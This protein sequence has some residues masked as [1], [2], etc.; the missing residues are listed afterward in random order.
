MDYSKLSKKQL[1]E[2]I[3]KQNNS[4]FPAKEKVLSSSVSNVVQ[5]KPHL[6]NEQKI[7]QNLRKLVSQLRAENKELSQEKENL[8][9]EA[10]KLKI[11]VNNI[12]VVGK[13]ILIELKEVSKAAYETLTKRYDFKSIENLSNVKELEKLILQL[14]VD[15]WNAY[16]DILKYKNY[17]LN[18]SSEKSNA[19]AKDLSQ[20]PNED[21]SKSL[22][23]QNKE[24]INNEID[25]EIEVEVDPFNVDDI[26]DQTQKELE[27]ENLDSI[28]KTG[29]QKYSTTEANYLPEFENLS[30]EDPLFVINNTA[31][32]INKNLNERDHQK[33]HLVLTDK[34]I[35]TP[36]NDQG[37]IAG[38][39]SLNKDDI[40]YHYCPNCGK[41]TRCKISTIKRDNVVSIIDSAKVKNILAPVYAITCQECKNTF[42]Y[43][44]TEFEIITYTTDVRS[45]LFK[46]L[47]NNDVKEESE[48]ESQAENSSLNAESTYCKNKEKIDNNINT[49]EGTYSAGD[50]EPCRNGKRTIIG[51]AQVIS[52]QTELEIRKYE[53]KITELE[54]ILAKNNL[55]PKQNASIQAKIQY[56]D[57]KI[58]RLLADFLSS[59]PDAYE[60]IGSI[61]DSLV[62]T[63][64][65][66]TIIDPYK[67]DSDLW[68]RMP[69]F[70]KSRIS[71]G[72]A[73]S[74][75]AFFTNLSLPKSRISTFLNQLGSNYS[76][77]QCITFIN[78]F[79]RAY[80]RPISRLI[81][82][83]ILANCSSVLM[84]ETP[85]KSK[86][87]KTKNGNLG[88]YTMWTLVS[89]RTSPIKAV[90]FTCTPSRSKN[91][92]VELFKDAKDTLK[93]LT[94]DMFSGYPAALKEL[95]EAYGVKITLTACLTHLRRPLHQYLSD[96]CLIKVYQ[97][98]ITEAESFANF[99]KALTKRSKTQKDLSNNDIILLSIYYF[100]NSIYAIESEVVLRHSFNVQTEEFKADLLQARTDSSS[101]VIDAIYKLARMFVAKNPH[102]FN[103]KQNNE[104][105]ELKFF[106][107]AQRR[108]AKAIAF[109]L[110][111]EEQMR[112]FLTNPEVE[113]NESSCERALRTGVL[114]KNSFNFIASPDGMEAFSDYQ[115]IEATCR[116]NSVSTVAYLIWLASN[117]RYRL[118][119]Q[120]KQGK[121]D[122]TMFVMPGNVKLKE[123]EVL[124]EE[125]KMYHS[126][127]LMCYDKVDVKGLTPYDYARYLREFKPDEKIAG[128]G[129]L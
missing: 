29:K 96:N 94:V 17:T 3:I 68:G 100:I 61:T 49:H 53:K 77:T 85:I 59:L 38:V 37:T 92:I 93:T 91:T 84:D 90:W 25:K 78:N 117:I 50:R 120:K 55:D 128:E 47:R 30:K 122:P 28:T 39:I 66:N 32:G 11:I 56:Y 109:L 70:L 86:F 40:I 6:D 15:Q 22:N 51:S 35:S 113:T 116:L 1:I 52:A 83:D 82:K 33:E 87:K 76:R 4:T 125:C 43:N 69:L 105:G 5:T 67:F 103:I 112:V 127:N 57:N 62:T 44:P 16:A 10:K 27:K 34:K 2:I 98:L 102:L 14:L 36:N 129:H 104:T 124:Y 71:V 89:S 118:I 79:A 110:N 31:S 13:N 106:G 58:R 95:E 18:N 24:N 42:D 126:K 54:K 115:T 26:Q 12:K 114:A 65:G 7:I 108:E 60:R 73:A 23:I 97:D 21:Q 88:N 121:D 101:L 72:L 8:S 111:N 119:K 123:P 20:D 64:E 80:I 48:Q 99:N 107:I 81:R 9:K 19:P 45:E 41:I 63:K 75:G 74:M 46:L